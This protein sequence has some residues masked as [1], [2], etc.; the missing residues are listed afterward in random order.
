MSKR[1]EALGDEVLETIA[2][3]NQQVFLS[4]TQLPMSQSQKPMSQSTS[5]PM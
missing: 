1:K 4:P 5:C 2:E 3:Y